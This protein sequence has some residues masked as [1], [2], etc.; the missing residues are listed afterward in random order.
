[1]I[2]NAADLL[3]FPSY[4]ENSPL[5]P[6]EAAAASLPVIFRDLPEYD[7][8]YRYPYLKAKSDENFADLIK[9]ITLDQ[10]FRTEAIT[11]SQNLIKQFDKDEIR[12][13]L[14]KLYRDVIGKHPR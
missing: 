9:K 6:I 12:R 4:Q 3:L 2:Y 7:R 8:L 14:L 5:V 1:M 13:Q 11:M 10:T